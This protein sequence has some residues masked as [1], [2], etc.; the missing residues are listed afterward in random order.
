MNYLQAVARAAYMNRYSLTV[1]IDEVG[2]YE[3][4][5]GETVKITKVENGNLGRKCFGFYLKDKIKD[6]WTKSG[7]IHSHTDCVN[8]IVRKI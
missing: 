7:H 8:D 1:I 3:T 6:S 5:K 4:R 2:F